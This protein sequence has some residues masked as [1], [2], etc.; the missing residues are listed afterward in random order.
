MLCLQASA[1]KLAQ[2]TGGK[3]YIETVW[4][5]GHVLRGLAPRSA[6]RLLT[7]RSIATPDIDDFKLGL[8]H[9]AIEMVQ[10]H[11]LCY[12]RTLAQAEQFENAVFF[13]G[14]MHRLV[15]YR[16]NPWFR[17]TAMSLVRIVD[18]KLGAE[19]PRAAEE[20]SGATATVLIRTSKSVDGI[21]SA[22]RCLSLISGANSDNSGAW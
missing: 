20:V 1:K 14:Q 13:A 2:A 7:A 19:L 5:R 16:D 18:G 4:G 10:E 12:R 22:L 8:V 17:S 21:G 3:H 11:L 9:P 6:T 15:V